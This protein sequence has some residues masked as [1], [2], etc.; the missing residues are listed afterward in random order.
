MT[1][2]EKIWTVF[3]NRLDGSVDFQKSWHDYVNGFGNAN[4]EYWLGLQNIYLLTMHMEYELR[5]ELENAM[6]DE[7]YAHYGNFSLSR[8]ALNPE[9]DGYRLYV[10][11]FTDGGAGD[12]LTAHV[13]HMFSTYDNDQDE[14]VQN[15]ADYWG[16]GFW[17]NS[18]GC[19]GAGLNARYIANRR[20]QH[21]F[22]WFPWVDFPQTLRASQMKM[23][24]VPN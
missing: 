14:H 10:G 23:R 19:G 18:Q 17:Y 24:R 4:G 9:N 6:G 2:N 7:V 20:L 16:G 5:V 21:A 8:N 12:A 22:S 11:K 15:C 13:G 1:T 3:Q